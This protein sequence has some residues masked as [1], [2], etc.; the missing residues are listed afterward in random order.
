M[1]QFDA[2]VTPPVVDFCESPPAFLSSPS[3]SSLVPD[4]EWDEPVFHDNSRKALTV[5][6]THKVSPPEQLLG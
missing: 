6:Q 5:K 2:D 3:S 4:V 1:Y